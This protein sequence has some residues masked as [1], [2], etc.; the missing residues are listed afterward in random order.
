M[1]VPS[2]AASVGFVGWQ[3]NVVTKGAKPMTLKDAVGMIG[4]EANLRTEGRALEIRVKV[5]DAKAAYG[6][7]R[8]TVEPVM[9]SGQVT[10]DAGRLTF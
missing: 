1:S 2:F 6:A 4:R 9:G 3:S 7:F 5:V 8:F 10:V